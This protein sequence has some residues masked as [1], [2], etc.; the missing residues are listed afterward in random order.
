MATSGT[1]AVE[2][3]LSDSGEESPIMSTRKRRMP[4]K[5]KDDD[6]SSKEHLIASM[7]DSK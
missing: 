5:L 2:E 7:K 1:G 4:A 3:V 6:L